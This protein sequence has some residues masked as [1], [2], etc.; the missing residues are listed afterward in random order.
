MTQVNPKGKI[1]LV[2]GANRGIGKAITEELLAKG[3]ERVYAGARK[4]ETL[5]ELKAQY[6]DRLVPLQLDVT[7]QNSIENAASQISDLD[8]LVNNA[9]VFALGGVFS[10]Q[11][12]PSLKENLDVNVWGLL[13]LSNAVIDPLRKENETAIINISSVAGLGNM[14]M[15]ATYSVSKAAVHSL[16]QGMRAELANNNTLVMGVYPGPIDTDMAAG[17]DMEKES[18][19]NVA[20]A[21]VAGLSEGSED[22]YPDPM[23]NQ[24]GQFYAGNP[25]AV[26]QQFAGFTG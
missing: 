14:P 20:K 9:G 12:V 16:T 25:K 19:Q 4:I 22:I 26:E 15:A 10:S 21:I 17:V 23:S 11:A 8:I 6:G 18:P 7:D 1:A 13:N 2:S 5:N 3:A 24:V